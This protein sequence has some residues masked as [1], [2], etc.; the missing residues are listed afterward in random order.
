VLAFVSVTHADRY[1]NQLRAHASTGQRN[2]TT[3]L[4]RSSAKTTTRRCLQ[5]TSTAVRFSKRT[6]RFSV[7]EG[8]VRNRPRREW[9]SGLALPRWPSPLCWRPEGRACVPSRKGDAI[10]PA[11][12]RAPRDRDCLRM[13]HAFWQSPMQTHVTT[14][15][16]AK[17]GTVPFSSPPPSLPQSNN[18]LSGKRRAPP[19]RIICRYLHPPPVRHCAGGSL[20]TAPYAIDKALFRKENACGNRI[21]RKRHRHGDATFTVRRL[22]CARHMCR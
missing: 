14:A 1:T 16:L 9:R 12:F 11:F 3:A 13:D 6:N 10:G 2:T 18:K 4:F 15:W 5:H 8:G 17:F 20:H 22:R 19:H 7:L 21:L